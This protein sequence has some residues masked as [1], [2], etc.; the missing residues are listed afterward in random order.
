MFDLKLLGE[1]YRKNENLIEYMRSQSKTEANT[2]EQIMI[3]YDFQA[4]T[5]T[6]DFYQAPE[7]RIQTAKW[8]ADIISAKKI[9]GS[10]MEAGVGEATM[11]VTL[12]KELEERCS[13]HFNSV[14]GFDISWSRIKAAQKFAKENGQYQINLF[15]GDLLN[16]PIRNNA[17]DLVYTM[18][19]VEPNGGKEK[20]I[21]QELYRICKR[22]LILIEPC[23]EFAGEKARERMKRHGYVTNLYQSAAEL[24]FNIEKYELFHSS[25]EGRNPSGIMIIRK[26]LDHSDETNLICPFACPISKK[27]MERY[28]DSSGGASYYC[29][30]SMLAYPVIQNI[31]CL[32]PENAVVATKYF[33]N[34]DED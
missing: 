32:L 17:F 21:L 22:Y 5:Y 4:G 12:M 30:E 19:A 2:A 13:R 9:S 18:H 34:F 16:I 1:I 20:E 6:K 10:I 3:S 31:P 11:L 24:G 8:I 7:S 14:Y 27:E 29:A 23:Y 28:E 15:T 25:P 26:D 33:N